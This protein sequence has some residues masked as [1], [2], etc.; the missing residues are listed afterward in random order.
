[1]RNQMREADVNRKSLIQTIA[2]FVQKILPSNAP[3]LIRGT[4]PKRELL[5]F[6]APPSKTVTLSIKTLDTMTASPLSPSTSREIIYETTP[7]SS[8][9][10]GEIQE[11]EDV[12]DESD[13][14]E[15]DVQQFCTKEFGELSSPYVTPYLYNKAYLDRN[16][17]IR[18][19]AMGNL[20]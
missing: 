6:S 10:T 5:N 7:K 20:E 9:D 11:E 15:T 8:L 1:M 17:G 16:F 12:D 3:L 2:D 14:T 4:P 19:D 18:E 13:V